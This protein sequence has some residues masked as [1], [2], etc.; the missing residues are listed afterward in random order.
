MASIQV[1]TDS[2]C[3]LTPA[4]TEE[5]ALRV[6]PLTIRFGAE[7]LVDREELSG[8]EFWDR[9]ITGPD[10]P[11]TAAPS[12]G[13]FQ[14][15]FL[16]AREAGSSGVVCVTISSGLSAT[17]QAACT[18]ADTVSDR[19]AVRVI[20]TQSV[21]MGQGLLAMAA[22]DMASSGVA[23]D[24]IASAIEDMKTR[25]H[26]YGVVDSLDYLRRE[27]A[28]EAPRTSSDRCCRSSPSSRCATGWWRSSPSSARARGP[29]STSPTR[30]STPAPSSASAPPTALPR[31]SRRSSK[32]CDGPVPSTSW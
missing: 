22:A 23:L 5:S 31:T 12:P 26:V 1:V 24:A 6:V 8:K 11:A 20:D 9:V 25:T 19:I 3:D 30:P 21:T 29:C 15:A 7:E 17:Y 16:E 18:A 28:S 10:M 27:A 4:T 14:Q 2:A 13:A 32:W